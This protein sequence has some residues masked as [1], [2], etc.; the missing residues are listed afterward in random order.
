MK[1]NLKRLKKVLNESPEVAA[2]Y[3]FGS[4]AANESLVNDLDILVLLYPDINS[5]NIYF[6][7]LERISKSLGISADEVDVLFFDIQV[8]FPEVLYRAV[9]EGILIK[10]EN[11][12]LLTDNI[13]QL[14]KYFL[15]NEFLIREAKRYRQERLEEFCAN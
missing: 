15:E 9:T 12:K 1:Y 13:E 6:E 7:L 14:S 3:L 2:A 10:N 5:Q 11:Q 4:A 8:T